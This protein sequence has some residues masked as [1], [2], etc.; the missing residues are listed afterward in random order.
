MEVIMMNSGFEKS[1]IRNNDE[2][3][4]NTSSWSGSGTYDGNKGNI[5]IETDINGDQKQIHI[6]FTNDDLENLLSMEHSPIPLNERLQTNFPMIQ[7]QTQSQNYERQMMREILN[8]ENDSFP[9]VISNYRPYRRS[10]RHSRSSRRNARHSR[11]RSS[12]RSTSV[13]DSRRSKSSRRSARD[14]TRSRSRR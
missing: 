14:S 1:N 2:E 8:E 7:N 10:R 9:L 13:R 6:D 12:R 3:I 5:D 4:S 11:R